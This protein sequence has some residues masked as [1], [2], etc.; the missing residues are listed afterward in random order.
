VFGYGFLPYVLLVM[1][2]GLL[3]SLWA[4]YRVR[5]TYAKWD[6]VDSGISMSAMDFARYLLNAQDLNEVKVETTPGSLTDHYDPRT[7]TLRISTG[8]AAR[9][10]QQGPFGGR[11]GSPMRRGFGP[12]GGGGYG[13]SGGGLGMPAGGSSA[14]MGG[15]YAFGVSAVPG[16]AAPLN[17]RLSVAQVAVIA[18][19]VGH[20]QQHKSHDPLMALRQA[21]VPVAQLGSTLAP[22]LVIAGVF[23]RIFNLAL[24]GL[25][26]FAV[27]V[28]FT[29]IT[30]PVEFGASRRALAFVGPMGMTGE[31]ADGARAVLGA[32][33]WTYVAAALTALLTFLYYAVLVSGTRR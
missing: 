20:A 8:V 31:R 23:M 12:M 27:A 5:T 15:G 33:G 13:R 11:G 29:F 26:F 30:L 9:Q 3:L 2:P 4:A 18:H 6:K 32:A 25:V 28:L 19:E 17:G 22:W 24:I 16:P 1:V 21:V 10:Q 14:P 7:R